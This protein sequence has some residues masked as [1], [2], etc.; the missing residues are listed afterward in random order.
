M[1]FVHLAD[2]FQVLATVKM[3]VVIYVHSR[4]SQLILVT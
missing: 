1:L 2:Q 3:A 4:I